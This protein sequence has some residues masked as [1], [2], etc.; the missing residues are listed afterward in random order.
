MAKKNIILDTNVLLSDSEC[1][2]NFGNNDIY[3]PLKVLEEIDNHKKRQDSVGFHA[4]RTIK[5]LDSLRASGSLIKG[6][7]I[8]KG[9]GLLRVM[10]AD[11][12][13]LDE[14]PKS[15]S[16]SNP[17]SLIIATALTV[18]RMDKK[19][20][21]ILVSQDVNM[22]VIADSLGMKSEDYQTSQVVDSSDVIYEGFSRILVDDQVVDSFYNGNTIYISEDEVKLQKI[23][24][25]PN[26]FV[27]LV[28]S[29]NEKKTAIGK[30]K[31][32]NNPIAPLANL[33]DELVWGVRPKNKEQMCGLDLLFDDDIPFVSLIGIAGSG[34]TLMAIMAGLEQVIGINKS[35]YKKIII[36][37][38]VQPMGRDIGFL[39][40]TMQEK[41]LPWL[42]PI[43]DNLRFIM[44]GDKST[45]EMYMEKGVIEVEALTYIRGRSISDAFVII[46]E[47]QNLTA[48]EVKTI[49]T[50][51]GENTKLVLT[52]DVEQIDNI[53][54][55]EVSNGLTYAVEKLKSSYLTGHIT[56]RKGERSKLATEAAKLL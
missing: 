43:A 5:L 53:Y 32:Y 55:N 16:H 26:E 31:D 22:R 8:E 33:D 54:T 34:K 19:R 50:R 6:V 17:D 7:R 48:H 3:I 46:D 21:C 42:K 39:P 30:F 38:P 51:I 25:Q 45:F 13:L 18:Q 24:L 47:A 23:K 11:E 29:S 56:F 20:K 49:I 10:R 28:S 15:I 36:S 4:R 35:K 44:G 12:I 1:L 41:I 9:L 37:R 52:G 14:L 2:R 40:G 27:M